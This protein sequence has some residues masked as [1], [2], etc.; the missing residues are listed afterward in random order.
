MMSNKK[1]KTNNLLDLISENSKDTLALIEDGLIA[2]MDKEFEELDIPNEFITIDKSIKKLGDLKYYKVEEIKSKIK[3][4]YRPLFIKYIDV[5]CKGYEELKSYIPNLI[6]NN[7]AYDIILQRANGRKLEEIGEEKNVSRERIRQI[8]SNAFD[9][10]TIYLETYLAISSKLN[11]ID[12]SLFYD[13]SKLFDFIKSENTIKIIETILKKKNNYTIVF[14]SNE[15]SSFINKNKKDSIDVI[16]KL[17]NLNDIFDYYERYSQINQKLIYDYN[18]RDFRFDIYKKYLEN[19]KYT[20]KGNL[21]LKPGTSSTNTIMSIY[22]KENY[23]NGIILDDDGLNELTQGMNKKYQYDFKLFSA[24][25]KI[26]E[27]NPELIL[28]GKLIR[29]HIDNVHIDKD[30]LNEIINEFEKLF[31]N[32]SY[33]LLDDVF[34]KMNNVLENTI[35]TDKYRLYGLLKY[36]L[37]DKYFFRKMA[38]RKNQFKE[39]T[40]NELIHNYIYDHDLCTIDDLINDLHISYSSCQQITRDDASIILIND[41]YTLIERISISQDCLNRL[42]LRLSECVTNKYIHRENFYNKYKDEWQ[43]MEVYDYVMLYNICKFYFAKDYNFYTPYI[44]DKKYN[45]AI[46]YKIIINEYFQN[47]NGL[48]DIEKAQKDIGYEIALKDFSLIYQLRNYGIKFFRMSL[49]RMTLL[50]YVHVEDIVKR[51]IKDRLKFFFKDHDYATQSDLDKLCLELYYKVNNEKCPFIS[52]SLC[53]FVM[54]SMDEYYVISSLGLNNYIS[55]KYAISKKPVSYKQF[56]YEMVLSKFN[57]REINKQD[58]S[59]YLRESGLLINVPNDLFIDF[60]TYTNDKI[61]FNK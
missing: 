55:T 15:F 47:K 20:F 60:A 25:S 22:I 41:K 57:T 30:K 51:Q 23:P 50:D 4:V 18:I 29:T 42:K 46:T 39:F 49:D 21:A 8:E 31:E 33:I 3:R 2:F 48:I 1:I 36:Y 27:L 61:I 19:K 24:N 5:V 32:T 53:S 56:L 44:Q 16:N 13:I 38:V 11:K 12:D 28:W 7:P 9:E 58:V 35:I 6:V 26:D 54:N 37:K 59:K 40:L 43:M 10:I 45:Y 14:Y 52:Y 17:I 34:L